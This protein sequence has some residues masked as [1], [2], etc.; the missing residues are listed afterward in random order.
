MSQMEGDQQ[1]ERITGWMK[2]AQDYF[3]KRRYDEARG[4]LKRIL[5]ES[6]EH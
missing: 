3:E 5:L 1:K 4:E 6:P 2:R